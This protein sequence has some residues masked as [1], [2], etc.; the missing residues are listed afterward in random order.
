MGQSASLSD[1]R[2]LLAKP[3]VTLAALMT[4]ATLAGACGG[5]GKSASATSQTGPSA[6]R[7]TTAVPTTAPPI[8]ALGPTT[9]LEPTTAQEPTTAAK[10]ITAQEPTT[11]AKTITASPASTTSGTGAPTATPTNS[12]PRTTIT[13]TWSPA[14][15]QPTPSQ[16]SYALVDAWSDHDRAEALKD[17]SPA[18]VTSLFSGPYPAGGPQYR[19]CSTP[20][21]NGPSSCV[22]RSGNDLLSLTITPFATGWGVTGASLES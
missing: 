8:T 14:A 11:A 15:P 2:R 17:A 21:G 5:S 9:A 4:F 12:K 16:A 19:G 6:A 1:P 7:P 18:A 20:P 10:T 3:T 13:R 22:W